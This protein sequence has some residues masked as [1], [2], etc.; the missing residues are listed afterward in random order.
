MY[1]DPVL[2]STAE[3]CDCGKRDTAW[4]REEGR[5]P[6]PVPGGKTAG[7]PD[8][9]DAQCWWRC[10]GSIRKHLSFGQE[11]VVGGGEVSL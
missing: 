10:H 9:E 8:K 5:T 4:G 3:D 7:K 2:R 6:D 11:G 1:L